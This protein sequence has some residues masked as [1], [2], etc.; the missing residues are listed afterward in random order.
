MLAYQAGKVPAQYH[1][2]LVVL[3]TYQPGF[4]VSYTVWHGKGVQNMA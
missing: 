4:Y 1:I 2:V 3:M